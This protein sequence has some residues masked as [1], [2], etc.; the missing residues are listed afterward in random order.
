[1]H[2]PPAAT[3][4]QLEINLQQ[5]FVTILMFCRRV[6]C[7][8]STVLDHIEPKIFLLVL[9]NC[10]AFFL[11]SGVNLWFVVSKVCSY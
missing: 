7:T 11:T 3:A 1:M 4:E 10:E 2:G 9:Q 6:H 8:L 5:N